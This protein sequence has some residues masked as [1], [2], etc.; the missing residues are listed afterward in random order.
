MSRA[1]AVAHPGMSIQ[2]KFKRNWM[3]LPMFT[4]HAIGHNL[5]GPAAPKR[6]WKR[7]N[8][9]LISRVLPEMARFNLSKATVWPGA[10]SRSNRGDHRGSHAC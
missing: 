1:S 5:D 8:A 6:N 3:T 4:R 2:K 7:W 9:I 10:R